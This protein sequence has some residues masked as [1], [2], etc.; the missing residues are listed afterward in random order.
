MGTGLP[1]PDLAA[2]NGGAPGT[3]QRRLHAG[4]W[5]VAPTGGRRPTE[6]MW[7]S[8]GPCCSKD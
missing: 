3:V 2:V 1:G 7:V 4:S 5:P 6:P 8:I